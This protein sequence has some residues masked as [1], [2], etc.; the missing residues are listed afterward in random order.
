MADI[1]L[2][3]VGFIAK[4]HGY[5]GVMKLS[6]EDAFHHAIQQSQFLFV[7]IES[8]KVPF[9]IDKLHSG[10][11]F[12]CKLEDIDSKESAIQYN[13]SSIYI[14]RKYIKNTKA[15]QSFKSYVGYLVNNKDQQIGVLNDIQEFPQQLMGVILH[16]DQE[17]LIPLHENLILAI[18]H[19][20][21]TIT[22]ELPDGLLDL[23]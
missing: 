15:E 2:V 10:H 17:I 3:K 20:T 18:D 12:F 13:S 22:L 7:D 6:I 21:K 4:T 19:D 14:E 1:D 23:N 8:M 16:K 11:H 9:K 5:E